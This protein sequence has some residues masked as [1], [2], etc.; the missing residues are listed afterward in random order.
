MINY[1]RVTCITPMV[2]LLHNCW[3]CP[4]FWSLEQYQYSWH[5]KKRNFLEHGW[6][7][8]FKQH[9]SQFFNSNAHACYRYIWFS[10]EKKVHR[11]VSGT[12]TKCMKVIH[13]KT[14]VSIIM[15]YDASLVLH[16]PR[17]TYI[18]VPVL[19]YLHFNMYSTCK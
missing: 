13:C 5:L 2:L 10:K 9:L 6:F 8:T 11:Y 18:I 4:R 16:L 3:S 14:T 12:I 15:K 17:K 1:S 7:R 19:I